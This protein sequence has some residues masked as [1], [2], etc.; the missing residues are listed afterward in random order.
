[1]FVTYRVKCYLLKRTFK[2]PVPVGWIVTL[3]AKT[4]ANVLPSGRDTTL[5]NALTTV[6]TSA[7][8]N[9]ALADIGCA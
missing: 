7:S 8:D 4:S 1:V 5:D 6:V 3:I 2:T 9:A